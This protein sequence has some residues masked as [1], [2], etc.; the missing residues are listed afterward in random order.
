MIIGVGMTDFLG[1][2]KGKGVKKALDA[3]DEVELDLSKEIVAAL[4]DGADSPNNTANPFELFETMEKQ[5]GLVD[6]GKQSPAGGVKAI[7]QVAGIDSHE[8]AIRAMYKKK[9]MELPD[10]PDNMM[11]DAMRKNM[12]AS[13]LPPE[14]DDKIKKMAMDVFSEPDAGARGRKAD[15]YLAGLAANRVSRQA[16][17]ELERQSELAGKVAG[18]HIRDIQNAL[19]KP[20]SLIASADDIST[21]KLAVVAASLAGGAYLATLDWNSEA[22][23]N[24]DLANRFTQAV[25]DGPEDLKALAQTYKELGTAADQYKQIESHLGVDGSLNAG[26]IYTLQEVAATIAKQI[27]EQGPASF[28]APVKQSQINLTEQGGVEDKSADIDQDREPEL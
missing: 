25:N 22:E 24:A 12:E 14:L 9:N 23:K 16:V 28:E 13:E 21:N 17:Q 5:L 10:D 3:V 27:R 2:G 6:A 4:M 26:E 7:Y 1:P 19:D 20:Q 15:E 8:S 11:L 18:K